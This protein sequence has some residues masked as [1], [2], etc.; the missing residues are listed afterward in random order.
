M[1]YDEGRWSGT[2]VEH[3]GTFYM[4]FKVASNFYNGFLEVIRKL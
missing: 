3:A 4:F 2:L 1:L